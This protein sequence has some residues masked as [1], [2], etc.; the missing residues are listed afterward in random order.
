[1]GSWLVLV[2]FIL[3]FCVGSCW[4]YVLFGC[5]GIVGSELGVCVCW[6]WVLVCLV[7]W[8]WVV[9]GCVLCLLVVKWVRVK[10]SLEFG[11]L[12]L[13]SF[14][15]FLIVRSLVYRVGV[16]CW[17]VLFFV[18]GGR[19]VRL[20]WIFCIFEVCVLLFEWWR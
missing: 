9:V 10:F 12:R 15:V 2:V 4:G 13:V 16:V 17:V 6:V 18:G 11:V 7:V 1:M 5:W 14:L 20:L 8:V 19:M 3:G